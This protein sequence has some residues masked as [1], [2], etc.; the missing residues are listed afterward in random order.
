MLP[1]VDLDNQPPVAAD[2][3]D[4]VRPNRFLTNEFEPAELSIPKPLPERR[5]RWGKRAS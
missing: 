5:F 1:A 4:L 2:E 3:F